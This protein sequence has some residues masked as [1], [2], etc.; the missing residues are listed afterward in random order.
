MKYVLSAIAALCFLPAVV[1]AQPGGGGGP[2]NPNNPNPVT[3]PGRP[4]GA[5]PGGNPGPNA[6]PTRPTNRPGFGQRPE[7]NRPGGPPGA[8]N[9]RPNRPGGPPA[10]G[11]NRPNRP[12][13]PTPPNQRPPHHRPPHHRPP[14]H[15]PRP[16]IGNVRPPHHRPGVWHRP[17]ANQWYWRGRWVNRIRGPRF[18]WPRG[19]HYRHWSV[20]YRLPGAF[21]AAQFFFDDFLSLGLR[22]PPPGFRWVRFG[23]DLFL[24]DMRTGDIVDAAYGVFYY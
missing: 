19:Y 24:V 17:R 9:N 11:N 2:N 22:P 1:L 18:V 10:G 15:R 21:L 20:G 16:P 6:G 3:R 23:P 4:P 7:G 14:H 13:R 5:Q 12:N 8:G